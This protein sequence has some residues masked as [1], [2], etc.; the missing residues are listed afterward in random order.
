MKIR[1]NK[2]R[3]A[4]SSERGLLFSSLG[5]GWT[6]REMGFVMEGFCGEKI[7]DDEGRQGGGK[8]AKYIVCPQK[9]GKS[10]RTK[11]ESRSG[12]EIVSG[13]KDCRSTGIVI[14]SFSHR[15]GGREMEG[16][17]GVVMVEGGQHP[18]EGDWERDKTRQ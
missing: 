2:R 1:E 17:R 3:R 10:T 4:Q 11:K 13:G 9:T 7:I 8:G 18:L 16:F 12:Q 5:V 6:K 14:P 15:G